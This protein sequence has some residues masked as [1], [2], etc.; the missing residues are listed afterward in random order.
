MEKG[1][2]TEGNRL[3]RRRKRLFF[4]KGK[5][6]KEKERETGREGRKKGGCLFLISRLPPPPLLL[7]GN[8]W[9]G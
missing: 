7:D 9:R 5:D 6:V 8:I 3:K 1:K 4:V 2:I